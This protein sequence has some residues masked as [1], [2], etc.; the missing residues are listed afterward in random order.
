MTATGFAPWLLVVFTQEG[1][2]QEV[3]VRE[4]PAQVQQNA[5]DY[6]A[7][8]AALDEAREEWHNEELKLTP[9]VIWVREFELE[10]LSIVT[11]PDT[12]SELLANT[13]PE[14]PPG[15]IESA[16]NWRTRGGRIRQWLE[17]RNFVINWGNNY[18][19][20]WRGTI[21]SS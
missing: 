20:D 8:Y 13:A 17:G 11:F 4:C 9:G 7:A 2:V 10:D 12:M 1:R 5:K 18:W 16:E 14:P 6:G 19:A 3:T 21:H 15:S